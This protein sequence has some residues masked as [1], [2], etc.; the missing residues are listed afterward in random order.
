MEVFEC[1]W[2]KE[3]API[4][5]EKLLARCRLNNTDVIQ[6][7]KVSFFTVGEFV[8]GSNYFSQNFSNSVKSQCTVSSRVLG[9]KETLS[10]D[11]W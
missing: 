1:N 4:R 10:D 3:S 2:R 6:L 8:L 11:G 7:E 5:G 9:L